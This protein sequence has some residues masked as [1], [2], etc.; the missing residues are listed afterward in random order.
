MAAEARAR[1]VAPLHALA[2][3]E[4]VLLDVLQ[5]LAGAAGALDVVDAV[6]PL[7]AALPGV[8]GVALLQRAGREAVVVGSTGYD[9]DTMAP[10][11][12]LPLDSGLP[13]TEA[14]RTGRAVVRG[15]GPGWCAVP[16]GK[17]GALLLSCDSA[18]PEDVSRLERV[19][20][21]AGAALT[22]VAGA[23]A[24]EQRL[25]SL[26]T[27]LVRPAVPGVRQVP[28]RDAVGGDVVLD[29][30]VGGTRWL[31]VADVCGN[32]LDAAATALA[33]RAATRALL[34]HAAGPAALLAAL[35]GVLRPEVAPD[36]FVTAVAVCV[37]GT[38]VRVATAGHPNP[39]VLT[40]AVVE[41]PVVPGPPL[42]L[43]AL[44]ALP[45]LAEHRALLPLG[46]LL[47]LYTDGLTDDRGSVE[48]DAR[49]LGRAA[50][51]ALPDQAASLLLAAAD[52][53]GP[54]VDDVSVLVARLS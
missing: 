20:A 4:R 50:I 11:A 31:V 2:L 19:A 42:A 15:P 38:S 32:G 24:V 36:A 14:I 26:V 46:A 37:D 1:V 45:P 52:A 13:A 29:E 23:A 5:A 9:C 16:W 41:L 27:G 54:A 17:A 51:G 35:D 21:A 25:A 30:L 12:R 43:A 3:P 6:C 18:P 22:R 33:V 39:L 7:L 34:P 44:D 53:A 49:E 8:R 48:L 10:G 28:L 40:D 47:V